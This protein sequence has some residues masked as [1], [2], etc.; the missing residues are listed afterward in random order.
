MNK[1]ERR[2]IKHKRAKEIGSRR[3]KKSKKCVMFESSENCNHKKMMKK[4]LKK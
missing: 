1:G 2:R 4:C 3:E